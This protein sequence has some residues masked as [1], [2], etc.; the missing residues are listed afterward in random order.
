[1]SD[2]VFDPML[3]EHPKT[4]LRRASTT[5]LLTMMCLLPCAF[6]IAL[7]TKSYGQK[8][9]RGSKAATAFVSVPKGIM[10]RILRA[11][12]ERRWDNDLSSLL[13][14]GNAAVRRRAALAGG[15]I[16]DERTV[17]SLVSLLQKDSDERAR[18]LAVFALGEIE[19]AT[20]ADVLLA[21][22]KK[23]DE[24]AE[25]RARAV[26]ALGKITAAL[27][28]TEEARS[29]LLGEAIAQV[30]DIEARRR[31]MPEHEVILMGLT[32]ALRARPAD[33]GK[34][35]AP[36]LSHSDPRIRA[37]AANALARLRA[38]DGNNQLRKLLTTDQ[39]AI[40][41]ANAAR[42]LGATKDKASFDA[43]LDRALNDTDSRVR[44][45]AIRSLSS[46]KD[47]RAAEPLLQRS[48][49]L[50]QQDLR[51]RR[52][53]AN[54]VLE[55]ATTLGRI[56][57]GT[58]DQETVAWLRELVFVEF[59]HTAPEIEI[60]FARVS[61]GNYLA[62]FGGEQAA[63]RKAQEALLLD[64]R[65]GSNL[66]Q[67]LGEIASLPE[68]TKDRSVLAELAQNILRSM[69]DYR[70]SGIN[71]NTL[72]AVHSEYAMPDILRALAA[73]KPQDLGE[74]L[75][76]QLKES[77]VIVRAT[78]AELLG[79]L[80]PYEANARALAEAL[81]QSMKDEMNDAAL[82]ILDALAQQK[83]A[84][85]YDAIKSALDSSDHL[86][87]RRAV[88]LLKADGVGDF[89][90]RIGT[91]QTR[92][93]TADYQRA[94][95]RIGKIVRALVSTTRGSFTIDLLPDDAP[96]N[97]DNFIQLSKRGYF[98]GLTFHR[99]VPNFVIQ[100]G[101]PRGDGNGGPGY[102][103]RCEINEVPYERGA[104]GMALSG[105]DTG[106]SQWFVTH[107][108]QPHLEGG[109]TVFGRVSGDMNVVDSITRGDVIR[110]ITIT[111]GSS[112]AAKSRM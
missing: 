40:V 54:E 75:R 36:F 58:A 37:D 44:V 67:G 85:A 109:Y 112:R 1:V 97:V 80:P 34:T 8:L 95:S 14:D 69:L 2:V 93:T 31:S 5:L 88:A 19:S 50:A 53:Q 78:A 111:E 47:A 63:K 74:V 29:R 61:P 56:L 108:P 3:K 77:D 71:I 10:L 52:A 41:R 96:L 27:P 45:S 16:G 22:L 79:E 90:S 20:A 26:E 12:D 68:A 51:T 46:L 24:S 83:S 91:V 9:E 13:S 15:R 17:P 99:V 102:Q 23:E 62:S 30:L 11:E 94:I 35:I 104:V 32:A 82:A 103:I 48:R 43:L 6:V 72:V 33:A 21:E 39:D 100:G 76:K 66:A 81:P 55:I 70:N 64:W 87:R 84:F 92:N 42:V 86:I 38:N 89:S 106:G 49:S 18:V 105:K 4:I 101:D 7:V 73:F 25:L 65:A 107:S 60:A 28:K 57:Q 59:N 98:R 110:S